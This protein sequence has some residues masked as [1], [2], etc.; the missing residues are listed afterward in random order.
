[1]LVVVE[2][3]HPAVAARLR[4]VD[5]RYTSGRRALVDALAATDRPLTTAE[6]VAT[7]PRLPQ[8]STYRSLA[9]LEQ[10]GV[11]RRV[12]GSDEY[13][14]FE[15]AEELTGRHHHHLVCVSC[16]GVEDFEPPARVERTLADAIGR[17]VTSTGF[18][19]EAHRL[20]VLGTCASG[21]G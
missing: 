6:L 2:D 13:S 14:R 21:A 9:V 3:L 11:V 15:L 5:Q 19:A 4:R 18:R 7:G 16:G 10:A 20:D 1:M 12:M 8:S 17:L